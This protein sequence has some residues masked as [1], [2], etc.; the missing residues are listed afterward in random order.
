MSIHFTS[1][2]VLMPVIAL[3]VWT[4]VMQIWMLATR[5]GAMNAAG[6]DPQVGARAVNLGAQ[7]PDAAQFKADNYN[8]LL[9]QPTIFYAMALVLA[10]AGLGAG[11]NLWMAWIYVGSRVLHSL[12]QATINKVMIRF[13]LYMVGSIALAVMAVNGA[14]KLMG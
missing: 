9:E 10:V 6:L 5:I 14:L 7:M 8:H 1:D 4:L 2:P 12:V 3:V 13:M 11:L